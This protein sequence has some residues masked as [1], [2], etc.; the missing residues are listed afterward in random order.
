MRLPL[1]F[2]LTITFFIFMTSGLVFS[3]ENVD[4]LSTNSPFISKDFNPEIGRSNGFKIVT[5]QQELK[6]FLTVTF[7]DD[8]KVNIKLEDIRKCLKDT[9]GMD[10]VI[11]E[12]SSS[13]EQ[14]YF[15]QKNIFGASSRVC[16]V[17]VTSD[18][19]VIF[20]AFNKF[21][22]Y[23]FGGMFARK[24]EKYSIYKEFSHT[25]IESNRLADPSIYDGFEPAGDYIPDHNAEETSELL[26]EGKRDLKNKENYTL[27]RERQ[28]DTGFKEVLIAKR[29]YQI[30]C[31]GLG[32][33]MKS[34]DPKAVMPVYEDFNPKSKGIKNISL[35][36]IHLMHIMEEEARLT[37]L[38]G[39]KVKIPVIL[40]A[41]YV[42][43]IQIME[44]LNKIKNKNPGADF[45]YIFIY[46]Q[47]L[48]RR[49]FLEIDELK[50]I[51]DK[52][53]DTLSD[54][55]L[56]N[57][58]IFNNLIGS[59]L[60]G[61]IPEIFQ[62]IA[63]NPS[64]HADSALAADKQ[65]VFQEL[66]NIGVQQIHFLNVHHVNGSTPYTS[67]RLDPLM[68]RQSLSLAFETFNDEKDP[69]G[70]NIVAQV[71]PESGAVS[72]E[73]V[74]DPLVDTYTR[75]HQDKHPDKVK[76]F[77]AIIAKSK[78]EANINLAS[79]LVSIAALEKEALKNPGNRVL[80]EDFKVCPL[81]KD[82]ISKI[83]RD[84]Y[85]DKAE[86]LIKNLGRM[87][88][89]LAVK[90]YEGQIQG[91]L[92]E[93][94]SG[95]IL[96]TPKAKT[97]EVKD[98]THPAQVMERAT[99]SIIH[100]LTE[101]IFESG[102]L[103]QYKEALG[104]DQEN[105][106]KQDIIAFS[107]FLYRLQDILTQ[108]DLNES[109]DEA[110]CIYLDTDD[111]SFF[112]IDHETKKISCNKVPTR[113]LALLFV[114]QFFKQSEFYKEGKLQFLLSA[115]YFDS[116]ADIAF[117]DALQS[118]LPEGFLWE[119]IEIKSLEKVDRD[120]KEP[121]NLNELPEEME[122]ELPEEMENNELEEM[123]NIEIKSLEK[124][125]RDIE[126]PFNLNELPE[127]MHNYLMAL[128]NRVR[129]E[130]SFS[131]QAAKTSGVPLFTFS[132]D[133]LKSLFAKK[134]SFESQGMTQILKERSFKAV[135][136]KTNH[137]DG[138]NGYRCRLPQTILKK[139]FK[140]DIDQN[141][142]YDKASEE[143]VYFQAKAFA[144]SIKLAKE[145]EGKKSEY[146]AD[147]SRDFITN[148]YVSWDGRHQS[149]NYAK[150]FVLV[151][152][153]E[154]NSLGV[155][156]T[157]LSRAPT[158]M[159][160]FLERD[161]V[162][163]ATANFSASHN[164]PRD[165]G[166][167][168]HVSE[169]LNASA[170]IPE[171]E[172]SW[173][174]YIPKFIDN[175]YQKERREYLS[176]PREGWEKLEAS[177]RYDTA[178]KDKNVHD[179]AMNKYHEHLKAKWKAWFLARQKG[180]EG[181][182]RQ[183][184][185]VFVNAMN[186]QGFEIFEKIAK[187]DKEEMGLPI[188]LFNTELDSS[189]KGAEPNPTLARLKNDFNMY[190]KEKDLLPEDELEEGTL[191]VGVDADADRT[192]VTQATV[193]GEENP[194]LVLIETHRLVLLILDNLLQELLKRNDK[195]EKIQ[196]V[197]ASTW[198]TLTA[199]IWAYFRMYQKQMKEANVF[200]H[201][202][203][204]NVVGFGNLKHNFRTLND[205]AEVDKKYVV[206]FEES[207]GIQ[208]EA[209]EKGQKA[210]NTD[211]DGPLAVTAIEV[212][213]QK[214]LREEN[215]TLREKLD[216]IFEK[217]KENQ[218]SLPQSFPVV[219]IPQNDLQQNLSGEQH[220]AI[221]EA[222]ADE[223]S[224]E[225]ACFKDFLGAALPGF[226]LKNLNKGPGGEKGFRFSLEADN[227]FF[228]SVELIVRKSGTEAVYRSSIVFEC[229]ESAATKDELAKIRA[230]F[231][232]TLPE[233]VKKAFLP[234]EDFETFK[235][236]DFNTFLERVRASA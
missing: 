72:F 23:F 175:A 201:I 157:L 60:G 138:T 197:V 124:V 153:N 37:T 141:V 199:E 135:P 139:Y 137:Q 190:C 193:K 73:V 214:L 149:E 2:R 107:E 226:K 148:V 33:R 222:V 82:K 88:W 63:Y 54:N 66:K 9:L 51:V 36:E 84:K 234:S 156:V 206:A 119:N 12:K 204:Y 236:S 29:A 57:Y 182:E 127:E 235:E 106:I 5:R 133:E 50:K 3:K 48:S 99:R 10:E 196:I 117:K 230:F 172:E 178:K 98:A 103:K 194:E 81:D 86:D 187:E 166:L 53:K 92:G 129:Y 52:K 154:L 62:D 101:D 110:L 87:K 39:T 232:E 229:E 24:F 228:P 91:L 26:K 176:N 31:G 192:A 93:V 7:T 96:K 78:S 209:M 174:K 169:P 161:G 109:L 221:F 65:D 42:T 71:N 191:V 121:F 186:G 217:I 164:D 58:I 171:G 68:K 16:K 151:L 189:F 25:E 122:N 179:Q 45:S 220:K 47:S 40:M 8:E 167:K 183:K 195:S 44:T 125:D 22:A 184:L 132:N 126:E 177:E 41:S 146:V 17:R 75:M 140:E 188:T 205:D 152:R 212:L 97:S 115:E 165:I 123:E 18:Q 83:L 94:S 6:D 223:E 105:A 85:P 61:N 34:K 113:I 112:S 1:F 144:A 170:N 150:I 56:Y 202:D 145:I 219:K 136:L 89:Q 211:K 77:K 69:T 27:L 30:A 95:N 104:P 59:S 162:P 118:F 28:G 32:T 120:I 43:D 46:S 20:T 74:D 131:E 224:S 181:N 198:V 76:D 38:M 90:Q 163:S 160:G 55:Y 208:F 130:D 4:V 227:L 207:G 35:L 200:I 114:S 158:P 203:D 185:K 210:T 111:C 213:A 218:G 80:M 168:I 233:Y 216:Q 13:N 147:E 67:M 116:Q 173:D 14:E 180:K 15:Y 64:G 49:K 231:N 79:Y 100:L 225:N 215:L 134:S 11:V 102:F 143:M 108:S 142:L 70:S 159:L 155:E 21:D 19:K 128:K